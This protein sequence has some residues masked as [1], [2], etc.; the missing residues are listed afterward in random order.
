MTT[1][2]IPAEG[3]KTV[4]QILG[5]NPV[6]FHSWQDAMAVTIELLSAHIS[7]APVVDRNGAYIGF[8]SEFDILRALAAGQDLNRLTAEQLMVQNPIAVHRSTPI[9]EAIKL[10]ADNHLL[11]LPVEENGEVTYSVTRHDL[12]RA[13]VGLAVG[14]EE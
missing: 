2:G 13:S 5:T 1:V 6:R 14:I 3:F 8:I 11:N 9:A 10:M 4:G 12:L 7:G